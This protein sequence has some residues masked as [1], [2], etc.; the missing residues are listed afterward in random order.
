MIASAAMSFSSV[1]VVTNALRLNLFPVYD[2]KKCNRKIRLQRIDD[3]KVDEEIVS[4][5]K[6]IKIEGMMCPR[7]EAHV[8]KALESLEEVELA[9]ASFQAGT[10]V[11]ILKSEVDDLR[12]KQVVE[13]EDYTVLEIL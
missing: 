8:K 7:C 2:A 6:T 13:A 1:C 9:T 5:T 12:L 11:V 10:A 3:K 4:M